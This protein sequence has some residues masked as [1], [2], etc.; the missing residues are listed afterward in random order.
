MISLKTFAKLV[1][2]I[3]LGGF[4][5]LFMTQIVFSPLSALLRA[6]Q[7]PYLVY[8]GSF[9]FLMQCVVGGVMGFFWH[10]K[11]LH[12]EALWAWTLPLVW[13]LFTLVI[14]LEPPAGVLFKN[15]VMTRWELFFGHTFPPNADLKHVIFVRM[16]YVAPFFAASSYSMGAYLHRA[17]VFRFE[18]YKEKAAES[19]VGHADAQPASQGETV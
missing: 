2:H 11:F 18:P 12:K 19:Q 17:N 6:T 10:R 9:P 13:L 1:S 5:V 16:A 4:V 3:A 14:A 8:T 15:D 7:S